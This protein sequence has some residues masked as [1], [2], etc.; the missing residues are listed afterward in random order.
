[1]CRCGTAF[2]FLKMAFCVAHTAVARPRLTPKQLAPAWPAVAG[3]LRSKARCYSGTYRAQMPALVAA[4]GLEPK[5]IVSQL[6]QLAASKEVSFDLAPQQALAW[7]VRVGAA[8]VGG[9][10]R[11]E[12]QW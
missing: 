6:A 5:D 12:A 4:S 11:R 7:K 10:G 3:L 2:L 8:W 9:E 1:M